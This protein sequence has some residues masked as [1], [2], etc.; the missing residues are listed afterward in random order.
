VNSGQVSEQRIDQSVRRILRNKIDLGLFENPLVD[1]A[2]VSEQVNL[3]DYVEQG[4]DAQRKSI[5]LLNNKA[6]GQPTLPLLEGSKVFLDGIQPSAIE[7]F[8]QVVG[9]PANADVIV[10]YLDAVFN[11]NQ[12]AGSEKMADR[13]IAALLPDTDLNFSARQLEKVADYAGRKPLVTVVNL[14][15]PAI[16]TEVNQHSSALL[17]SFG[18]FDSVIAEAL[19]GVFNPGGKLPFEIPAS[20]TAVEQQ[21]EDVADDTQQPV[22]PYGHGLSY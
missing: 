11:G 20:M 4:I 22:F 12:P 2:A 14:N 10:L 18:V 6:P 9:D 8:A 1:E 21:L 13:I 3:A 5:V 19:F 16:L 7:P 17:G 15:R